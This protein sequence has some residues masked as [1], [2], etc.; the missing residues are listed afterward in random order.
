MNFNYTVLLS[1]F[2]EPVR[3]YPILKNFEGVANVLVL[4]DSS[5]TKTKS[6]LVD[7]SV[8]YIVRPHEFNEWKLKDQVEWYLKQI[9]TEYF[10]IAF[11]SMF[12]TK[13][14][15]NQFELVSKENKYDGIKTSMVYLSHGKIVQRP[16]LIKKATACYFYRKSSIRAEL[17]QIHD[18]FKLASESIYLF[19]KPNLEN[20]IHVYRDDD[21]PIITKKHIGYAK[22]EAKEFIVNYNQSKMTYGKIL[23]TTVKSFLS[24]YF[25]MGGFLAG[26]EGL[27]YHFNFAIYKYL[28]C[29]HIW[30]LQNNRT[31][32]VNRINHSNDRLKQLGIK[33]Q[34]NHE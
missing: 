14:L 20:S 12:F 25:R 7:K 13:S 34:F 33:Q 3:I 22:R 23:Y 1:I 15:L 18:E 29:S 4:L 5:D 31:F 21:M 6:I 24:G 9:T 8:D 19:L 17:A 27:L 11:A 32:T 16:F 30:E 2:N 10:L 28:V 26:T